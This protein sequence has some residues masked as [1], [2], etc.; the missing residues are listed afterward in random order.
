MKFLASFGVSDY[1]SLRNELEVITAWYS[2]ALFPFLIKPYGTFR[3]IHTQFLDHEDSVETGIVM[4]AGDAQW[5]S[6]LLAITG[7]RQV[8]NCTLPIEVHYG[9]NLDLPVEFVNAIDL[10]PNVKAVD[11]SKLFPIEFLDVPGYG[12][13]PFAMLASS[14][15]K[16]IFIDSD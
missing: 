10:L 14:F 13:K 12:I 2:R 3:N 16:I 7:L 11:L 15:S 5:E 4:S 8:M 6:L 9:G 1:E